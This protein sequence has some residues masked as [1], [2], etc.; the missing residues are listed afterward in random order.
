[1]PVFIRAGRSLGWPNG[2]RASAAARAAGAIESAEPAIRAASA[3]RATGHV[4][5]PEQPQQSTLARSPALLLRCDRSG[6]V[7]FALLLEWERADAW[8]LP[9]DAGGQM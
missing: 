8:I 5:H 9:L 1:M 6:D 3:I 7:Q 2:R 4:R